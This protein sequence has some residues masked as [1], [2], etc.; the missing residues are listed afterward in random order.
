MLNLFELATYLARAPGRAL[1]VDN[2]SSQD[3]ANAYPAFLAK[4]ISIVTP[5]KKAFSSD[6]GLWE[7]IFSAVASSQGRSL[8]YH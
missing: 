7:D 1:L 5:N 3:L 8:I 6:L 4:G 2:T